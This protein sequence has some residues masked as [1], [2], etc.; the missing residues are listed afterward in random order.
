MVRRFCGVTADGGDLSVVGQRET[1]QH[2]RG[3]DGYFQQPTCG[4]T[5]V[6]LCHRRSITQTLRSAPLLSDEHFSMVR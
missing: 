2:V 5:L 1:I 6:G 4:A 3:D